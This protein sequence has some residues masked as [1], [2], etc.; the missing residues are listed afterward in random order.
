MYFPPATRAQ[1][2][3]VARRALKPDGYLLLPLQA[4]PPATPE[5][6]RTPGGQQV[7][8]SRLVYR[9]WGLGWYSAEEV[10]AEMEDAGFEFVRVVPHP[11]TDSMLLRAPPTPGA[12]QP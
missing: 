4:E 1:T 12:G 3:R 8:L 5:A 11:R 10:R 2:A 9:V 7:A 6:L